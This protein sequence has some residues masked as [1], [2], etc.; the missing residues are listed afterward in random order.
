[1]RDWIVKLNFRMKTM[2]NPRRKGNVV[3]KLDVAKR[4][5]IQEGWTKC[6]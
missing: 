5:E 3:V 1:M 2:R 4:G 6:C